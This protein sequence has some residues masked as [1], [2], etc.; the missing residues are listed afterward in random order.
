MEFYSVAKRDSN[1]KFAG[2]WMDLQGVT[3]SEVYSKVRGKVG[4]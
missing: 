1:M 4:T 2:K 3:L